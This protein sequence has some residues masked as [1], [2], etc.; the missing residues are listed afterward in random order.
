MILPLQTKAKGFFVNKGDVDEEISGE[1]TYK[2]N[3]Y[4][5]KET[6]FKNKFIFKKI[7][8]RIMTQKNE[9]FLIVKNLPKK[10]PLQ[11]LKENHKEKK[12]AVKNLVLLQKKSLENQKKEKLN[13]QKEK[14]RELV[15]QKRN[16]LP[17]KK[18]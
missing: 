9:N 18:S 12:P 7:K 3:G 11:I 4:L 2:L 15:K 14:K 6:L 5:K 1:E 10:N 8:E 13:Q 16:P 17:M